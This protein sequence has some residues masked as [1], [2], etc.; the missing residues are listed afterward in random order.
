MP[1]PT[2]PVLIV[3]PSELARRMSIPQPM[4]EGDRWVVEQAIVDAQTD[5]ESYLGR[6]ITPRTYT[7]AG[8]WPDPGQPFGWHLAHQ[9]VIAVISSTPEVVD[10]QPTGRYSVVYTAGLDAATD[11]ALEPMRRLVRAHA[12]ASAP[13]RELARRLAPQPPRLPQSITVEGQ[14]VT[15]ANDNDSGQQVADGD[16]AVGSLPT[17]AS[18]DQWKVRGRRAYQEPSRASAPWPYDQHTYTGQWGA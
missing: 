6:P 1:A 17:F 4:T 2:S 13:L 3:S 15:Y 10:G 8:L 11:P 18:C 14:S 5:L 9:P 16:R 12:M 7:Q